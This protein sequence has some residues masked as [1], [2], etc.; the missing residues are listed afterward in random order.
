M[1]LSFL[2]AVTK[3]SQSETRQHIREIG[4]KPRHGNVLTVGKAISDL[5]LFGGAT[6]SKSCGATPQTVKLFDS[7]NR[8]LVQPVRVSGSE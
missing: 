8:Y 7:L 3:Q 2:N 4:P 1:S 6:A 5:G